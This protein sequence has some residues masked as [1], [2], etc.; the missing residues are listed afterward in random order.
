M[1]VA[2]ENFKNFLRMQTTQMIKCFLQTDPPKTNPYT[3]AGSTQ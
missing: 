1:Q 3:I 2:E